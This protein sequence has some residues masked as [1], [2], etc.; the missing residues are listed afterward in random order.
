MTPTTTTTTDLVTDPAKLAVEPK[1]KD[2]P[3]LLNKKDDAAKPEAKPAGAPE[4]YEPFKVPEGFALD[5]AVATEAG[6]LFKELGLSQDAGQKL[7]DLYSAK[8]A[9][10][11]EAPYKLYAE[12]R[13]KWQA[14]VKA[15][16]EI[17]GKLAEVKTTV[18][19]ALDAVAGSE[20]S[21]Q[22]RE[23]MDLT[24]AGDHPAF[25]KAFYKLAQAVGEGTIVKGGGPTV[26][27][28]KASGSPARPTAAHALYP[29]LVK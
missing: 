7:I 21:K 28:Q 12:T 10:A 17:G 29:N 25:I 16:P 15:D 26:P 6:T 23:A 2:E 14:D 8:T 19:R 22:F 1:A 27:G 13:Q 11:A 5:P 18:S 3:S 9:A 4:K 20:L 24:G